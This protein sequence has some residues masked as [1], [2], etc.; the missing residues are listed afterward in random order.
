MD[1]DN[2]EGNRGNDACPEETARVRATNWEAPRTGTAMM[3]VMP[4]AK[5]KYAGL[6]MASFS[7]VVFHF[8]FV[9]S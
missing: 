7:L 2:R 6:A 4:T 3:A 1:V 5:I 9:Y 8:A